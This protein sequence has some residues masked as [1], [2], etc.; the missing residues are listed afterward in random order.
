MKDVSL[1]E[2]RS[3]MKVEVAILG[4]PSIIVLMVSV[5]IKLQYPELRSCESRGGRPG[6]PIKSSLWSVCTQSNTRSSFTDGTQELVKE[7]VD[8]LGLRPNSP[9]GLCG[10][11]VTLKKGYGN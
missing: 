9:Y 4:S 2:L 5:D 1:S 8:D 7:E 6:L 11:Q 3:C 10:C